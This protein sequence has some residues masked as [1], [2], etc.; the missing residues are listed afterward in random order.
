VVRWHKTETICKEES[1]ER[2]LP[3]N[4]DQITPANV[5]GLVSG[6]MREGRDI[7]YKRE[8]PGRTG[9][10]K[11]EFLADV[12][13]FANATGGAIIFGVSEEKDANGKNTGIPDAI[14]GL[15]GCNL[16]Q[17]ILRLE[18]WLQ[19]GVDPR[20]PA[21]RFHA[22]DGLPAGQ[23]LVLVVQ[24]S[25]LRP[26]M[27][28]ASE[29]RFYSRTSAGK[30]P[31]DVTEIRTAFLHGDEITSRIQRFRDERLGLIASM[32]TPVQLLEGGRVVLHLVPL[33]ALE[34]SALVDIHGWAKQSPLPLDETSMGGH[35]NADGHVSYSGKE[36]PG[37]RGYVQLFRTGA[38]E[39]VI[40]HNREVD[41]LRV[42]NIWHTETQIVDGF[43]RYL[44]ALA[45][46]GVVPPVSVLLSLVGV[47]GYG[48]GRSAS[49]ARGGQPVV[50]R[51][52]ITLPDVLIENL[53]VDPPTVLRP[54][55]DAL[56]QTF[57]LSRS[58]CYDESGNW[59]PNFRW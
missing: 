44:P 7:D 43:K 12:T 59:D 19:S 31:L 50:K 13:S 28:S 39:A 42:L 58:F 37:H 38:V 14:V 3:F 29:S 55:F 1:R 17:E 21:H 48:L 57:E 56:W 51:N 24:Q 26:H 11:K 9:D 8:L 53:D 47:R 6:K 34:R 23:V 40:A 30:Y 16:D 10:A 32:E 27:V 35:F 46:I 15:G 22:V 20:L 54:V 49:R 25:W 36:D 33:S 18:Q 41:G 5:T 52:V 2:V 45:A 4:I